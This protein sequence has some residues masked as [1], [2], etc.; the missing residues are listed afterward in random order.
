MTKEYRRE[1]QRLAGRAWRKHVEAQAH[2]DAEA[3]AAAAH[4]ADVMVEPHGSIVLVRPATDAGEAWLRE[5]VQEDAQWWGAAL[6]VEPRY[7]DNLL[8]GIRAAGLKVW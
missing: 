5:N 2:A 3:K 8:D 6:V 7:L 4:P 1:A